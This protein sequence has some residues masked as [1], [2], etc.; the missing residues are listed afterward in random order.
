[1]KKSV[2]IGTFAAFAISSAA[3]AEPSF[4]ER[5]RQEVY[6]VIRQQHDELNGRAAYGNR[7]NRG[8]GRQ[9]YYGTFDQ[10]Y[11][12]RRSYENGRRYRRYGY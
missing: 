8:Y 7:P 4:N 6:N 12:D 1:M 10:G 11:E 5:D 3:Y 9:E 2:L